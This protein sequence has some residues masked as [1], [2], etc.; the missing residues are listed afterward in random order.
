LKDF[1]ARAGKLQDKGVSFFAVGD[2]DSAFA[3]AARW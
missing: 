2:T 1:L 3:E